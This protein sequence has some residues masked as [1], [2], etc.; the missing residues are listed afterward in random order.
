NTLAVAHGSRVQL[1]DATT[2]EVTATLIDDAP[3]TA[4]GKPANAAHVSLVESLA[5]SPDGKRLA[6][7]SFREVSI[8]NVETRKLVARVGGPTDKV[9][10]IA[11]H[12]NGEFFAAA[13]GPPT[14][15]GEIRFFEAGGK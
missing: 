15:D 5:F 8:W 10:A 13:G 14:E 11:W 12:P 3:K 2:G 4:E 1:R 9:T 6:T 7:G